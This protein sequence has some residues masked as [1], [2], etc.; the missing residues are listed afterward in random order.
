MKLLESQLFVVTK[1]ISSIA[2][3]QSPNPEVLMLPQSQL[4]SL[5]MNKFKG[6]IFTICN[7]SCCRSVTKSCPTLCDPINCSMPGFPVLHSLPELLK[8]MSIELVMPSNCLILCHPFFSCPQ[9]FPASGSFPIS[10]LFASYA[11][12]VYTSISGYKSNSPQFNKI[13]QK[14]RSLLGGT[15]LGY[16]FLSVVLILWGVGRKQMNLHSDILYLVPLSQCTV[17]C[18]CLGLP[19]LVT[20]YA[21]LCR[22]WSQQ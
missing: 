2:G 21:V 10:Q 6:N 11:I 1:P 20:F 17:I 12:S 14:N 18:F 5:I 7:N 16:G 3:T 19:G 4:V 22:R 15:S 13:F 8:L 9:S